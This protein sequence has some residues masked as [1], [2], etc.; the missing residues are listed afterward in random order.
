MRSAIADGDTTMA[1]TTPEPALRPYLPA[2]LPVLVG[3]FRAS[4][5]ELTGD[6]YTEAQQEAWA[7]VADDAAEFGRRLAASLALVAT[8]S[9]VPVGFGSLKGRDV[10]DLLYVHPAMARRG[11]GTLLC[12]A[13][14][15]LVGSRGETSLVTDASDT[16]RPFFEGRGF[17][18]ERRNTIA[19]DGEWLGSTTMRK[20]LTAN[21]SR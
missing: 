19:V 3:I 8:V 12:D 16:A 4:I 15:K 21:E 1:Q 18:A 10:I 20:R 2:D 17:V 14:E 7:S 13:L 11:I 5:E 6:D 9:G